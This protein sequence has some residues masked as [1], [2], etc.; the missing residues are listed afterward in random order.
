MKKLLLH[1]DTDAVPSAFDAVVAYDGGAD[2]LVQ[3]ANISPQNCEALVEGAIYTRAP[4]DK[5]NTAIFIS[6]GDMDAGQALLDAV[7]K[8][9]FANFRVSVMFDSNGCN[10]TAAAAV[11]LLESRV[12]VEGK[13]AIVLAGTGPV[14][15]R[16]A[17][18]LMQSGAREVVLSSRTLERAQKTCAAMERRFGLAP[19]PVECGND[20]QTLAAMDGAEIAF[21]AGK[22]GIRLVSH[23][24]WSTLTPLKAL[25]DV[26]TRPPAGFEGIEEGDCGAQREGK[27]IFGGLGIGALKLKLQR[28]CIGALFNDN[29][30]ILDAGEVLRLARK[31]TAA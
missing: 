13:R 14:G 2:R 4:K 11:A 8:C 6:G 20:A 25:A 5:K 31:L 21:A 12:A 19:V 30:Q 18:M 10:T 9:F 17:L 23:Q 24:Q 27:L 7:Q 28:A 3:Y 26:N 1:F 16:I 22:A 15:Q 29:K